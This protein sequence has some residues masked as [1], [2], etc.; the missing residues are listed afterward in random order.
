MGSSVHGLDVREPLG[1]QP[2]EH[3]RRS[4]QRAAR[5]RI[6]SAE[7][8]QQALDEQLAGDAPRAGAEADAERD[9]AGAGA[10]ARQQQ[11]GDVGAGDEEDG[12]D[13]AQQDQQRARGRRRRGCGR[14][15]G[16]SRSP[17][18]LGRSGPARAVP[19]ARARSRRSATP[20]HGR[21]P[22]RGAGRK[23][24]DGAVAPAVGRLGADLERQPQ[25]RRGSG[26]RSPAASPRRSSPGLPRPGWSGRRSWDRR[27]SGAATG[28]SRGSRHVRGEDPLRRP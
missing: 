21:L 27:H 18:S 8:E 12:A 11:V 16:Q 25:L 24:A 26:S 5:P 2:R 13:R 23:A 6:E 15:A 7:G 1:G 20:S 14:V 9:L 17:G 10:G 3:A 22:R 19:S 28:R 4:T